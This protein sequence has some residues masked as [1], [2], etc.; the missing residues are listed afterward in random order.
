MYWKKEIDNL[1]KNAETDK[2]GIYSRLLGFLS[3]AGYSYANHAFQANDIKALEQILFIYQHADP[4]NPE[5]AFM[6]AKLYALKNETE[7]TKT[8]LQEAMQLGIDKNR[9]TN[10]ALLK[11]IK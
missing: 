1:W 11:N 8:A 7:N 5:Q 4:A 10:D 6:R 2:S 3:L 9:I